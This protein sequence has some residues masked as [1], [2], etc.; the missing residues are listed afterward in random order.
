MKLMKGIT[1][2]IALTI[3]LL[4]PDIFGVEV[5][6]GNLLSNSTFGTGT[7]YSDDSWTIDEH[8]HGHHGTGSF[9]TVGGGNNPGGSVAAEEDTSVEQTINSIATAGSMTVPEVQKGFSSTLSAD[10]WFWNQYNNT[11]TLKQTITDSD[12]NVTIQQRVIED[13]G[14]GS[15]NCGQFTNY[16]DKHIQGAN[17][18][19][20]FSIKVGVHNTNNRS[21]HW[22]P[23]IDDVEL[24]VTYTDV[25][26][27]DTTVQEELDTIEEDWTFDDTNFDDYIDTDFEEEFVFEDDFEW[28]ENFYFEEEIDMEEY[29][30]VD[31]E[32]QWIDM[33]FEEMEMEEMTFEEFE[34]FDMD[35]DMGP[36]MVFEDEFI[37]TEMEMTGFDD[38]YMEEF[39]EFEEFEDAWGME[40]EM[41]LTEMDT[42]FNDM[43]DDEWEEFEEMSED[44]FTEF[45]EEE[46][47]EDFTAMREEMEEMPMEE[48]EMAM[49]EEMPMEPEMEEEMN[50]PEMEEE[51]NEPEPEM[52]VASNEEDDMMTDEPEPEMEE[53]ENEEV[54]NENTDEATEEPN[55][56]VEEESK[57]EDS[58]S[59]VAENEDEKSESDS[60]DVAD[61]DV[62]AEGETKQKTIQKAEVKSDRKISI[63][64]IKVKKIKVNVEKVTLFS[65]QESLDSYETMS[66]YQPEQIYTD[67]DTSFFDQIDMVEYNKQIYQN[68]RLASY[69]DNDPVEVHRKNVERIYMEKQR[70]LIELKQLKG[71]Q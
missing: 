4:S 70:L 51:M 52:E 64:E 71:Q 65:D 49:E 8:T 1:F 25:P 13:T 59:E 9:A 46:F 3:L 28:E 42:F 61:A 40:P 19:T 16:T 62:Q 48:P 6:T 14:C 60:E 17:S 26:P 58:P 38:V 47:P 44:E 56:N 15:I 63:D 11:L 32:D 37:N 2:Y 27:I 34:D 53:P 57:N 54:Q 45:L 33:D 22:G 23:D 35:M 18:S 5:N 43:S 24:N 21:G 66:F 12:G 10:V 67:V 31:F 36:E 7:T 69:M 50:E 30:T 39:E 55:E 41:E 68:V 20:D 29:M